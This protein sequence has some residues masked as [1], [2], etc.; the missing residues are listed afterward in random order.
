MIYC[1]TYSNLC[2]YDVTAKVIMVHVNMTLKY[3][4]KL[5][6]IIYKGNSII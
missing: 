2:K 6:Y 3:R 4:V 5:S 1:S